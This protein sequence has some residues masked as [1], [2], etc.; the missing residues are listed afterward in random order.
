VADARESLP[1]RP[2]SSS[3]DG[4][5]VSSVRGRI[6][7]GDVSV[8]DSIHPGLLATTYAAVIPCVAH[9]L[10]QHASSFRPTSASSPPAPHSASP[11][12]DAGSAAR[13]RTDPPRLCRTRIECR[14]VR[15]SGVPAR[16]CVADSDVANDEPAA[17]D[18]DPASS[19]LGGC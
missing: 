19:G 11:S 17:A 10:T 1:I 6:R 5:I 7:T 18:A 15:R 9:V 4:T 12:S 16:C 13:S 2:V 3:P 14:F 8:D